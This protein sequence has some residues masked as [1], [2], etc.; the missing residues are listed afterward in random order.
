MPDPPWFH[1]PENAGIGYHNMS[2]G[3]RGRENE[4]PSPTWAEKHRADH[5]DVN[6]FWVLNREK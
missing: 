4:L 6:F 1:T 3:K 5:P 2:T